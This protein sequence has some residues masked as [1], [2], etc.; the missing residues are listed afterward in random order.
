LVNDVPDNVPDNTPEPGA[1]I[2]NLSLWQRLTGV[3]VNPRPAFLDIA[4]HP[5]FI[6]GAIVLCA[7]NLLVA[8][9]CLPKLKDF[10]ALMMEKAGPM[11]PEAAAF[12]GIAGTVTS[13]T[14]ILGAVIG[15]L[16]F[17][18]L[19]AVLLLLFGY[20][21]SKRTSFR[22]LYAVSVF[23]YVPTTIAGLIQGVL[24]A[25]RPAED[26]KNITTSLAMFL[27]AESGSLA[28]RVLSLIDP[29]GLWSL[30]LL[31]LG[32]AVALKTS[33]SK[34]AAFIFI[35]WVIYGAVIIANPFG[36]K[37]LGGF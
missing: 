35:L 9:L 22:S 17:W 2:K 27:P 21:T 8:L 15:P 29:F 31:A 6:G 16:L 18:L 5:N 14:A 7:V 12:K 20:L 28:Y 4:E 26:L 13:V 19:T 30:A 3:I 25:L 36:A 37:G 11:P 10:T 34:T 23:A 33:F 1:G 24:I 32:G